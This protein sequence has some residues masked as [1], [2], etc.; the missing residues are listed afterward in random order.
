[1]PQEAGA[2]DGSNDKIVFGGDASKIDAAAFR[3]VV[4]AKQNYNY[5]ADAARLEKN[6]AVSTANNKNEESPLVAE[7]TKLNDDIKQRIEGI[8]GQHPDALK[9][10]GM[11]SVVELNPVSPDTPPTTSAGE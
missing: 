7:E 8:T 9:N 10:Y 4:E 6:L 1:M 5:L 3:E 2:H 11:S